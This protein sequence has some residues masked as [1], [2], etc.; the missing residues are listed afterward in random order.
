MI[1]SWV[2]RALEEGGYGTDRGSLT[3]YQSD[4]LRA[5][6]DHAMANSNFYIERFKG[7]KQPPA[8]KPLAESLH[9][10]PLTCAQDVMDRPYWFLGLSQSDVLR[11]YIVDVEG[12]RHKQVFYSKDELEHIVRAIATFF[13]AIGMGVGSRAA[14][15]FPQENE[16]GIPDLISKAVA[17]CGG[18][19][20]LI[21]DKDLEGQISHIASLESDVIVG[22]AQQ[23]FYMSALFPVDMG[24]YRPKAV[25]PCHGC[26]PYLFTEKAKGLVRRSWQSSIYEHFGITEIGFNVA[27]GCDRGDWLHL[28]EAD[29]FAEVIEP[30]TL[31][32]VP[33]GVKGELVLTNLVSRAMPIIRYRTGYTVTVAGQGCECGDRL[34]RRL[35]IH[36]SKDSADLLSQPLVFRPF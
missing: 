23:L 15:V 12:D 26:V 25:V 22:S 8:R 1:I 17:A 29:V 9:L 18:K 36:S 27:V 24:R 33:E 30:E 13:R 28:N 16:W 5:V 2:R 14:I 20:T 31:K 10:L 35:K 3:R 4:R 7:I 21:E 6:F 34:T 11:S 32:P 19:P